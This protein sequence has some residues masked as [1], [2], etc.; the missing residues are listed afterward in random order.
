VVTLACVRL[1]SFTL[2]SVTAHI[3]VLNL[4]LTK[5]PHQEYHPHAPSA[6]HATRNVLPT[7]EFFR[8][9]L[10]CHRGPWFNYS[11]VFL[12]DPEH[13]EQFQFKTELPTAGVGSF[14]LPFLDIHAVH[15]TVLRLVRRIAKSSLL[16]SC[17]VSATT[18]TGSRTE[19]LPSSLLACC[20]SR[21]KPSPV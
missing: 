17:F 13:Q 6:M 20:W 21:K 12:K 2:L 19:R 1:W 4:T 7:N 9:S 3:S 5:P 18:C 10:P 14:V 16:A 8:S 11:V 15:H